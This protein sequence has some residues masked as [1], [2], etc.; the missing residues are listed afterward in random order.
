MHVLVNITKGNLS[1]GLVCDK[2]SA[3]PCFFLCIHIKDHEVFHV[4]QKY[5]SHHQKLG[6]MKR[7][8]VLVAVVLL[9]IDCQKGIHGH[10]I[11]HN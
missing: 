2:K 4:I 10:G 8:G 7:V 5:S 3:Y 9:L 6:I 11:K 1:V